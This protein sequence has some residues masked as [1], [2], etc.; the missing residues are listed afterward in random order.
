[1]AIPVNEYIV[2]H[3][4][5][6]VTEELLEKYHTANEVNSFNKWFTGQTGMVMS[7]G[8]LGI[9]VHDYERWIRQGRLTE[10]LPS[11]WD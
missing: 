5:S 7:D 2:E 4:I 9:Y 10:Q 3:D 8:S 11:D 6:C 1:M